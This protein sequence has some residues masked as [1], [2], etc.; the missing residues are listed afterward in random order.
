MEHVENDGFQLRPHSSR[1]FLGRGIPGV[2]ELH[3]YQFR[4]NNDFLIPEQKSKVQPNPNII[5]AIPALS[6]I[7][8]YRQN[9]WNTLPA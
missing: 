2:S 9:R 8:L 7:P 1:D 5:P 3:L 6:T 4:W